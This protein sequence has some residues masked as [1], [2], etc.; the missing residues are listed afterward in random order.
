M[1]NNTNI[2]ARLLALYPFND[3]DTLGKDMSGNNNDAIPL[4]TTPPVI[5][6]VCGR[7]AALLT[8]G[9]AGT[10]YF[11]LPESIIEG[12]RDNDGLTI[13][14][15]MYLTRRGGVWERIIDLGSKAG[16][17][18]FFIT[19]NLR[20]V[21]AEGEDLAADPGKP[22]PPNEWVH[23]AMTVSG[24]KGGTLSNAGPAMYINGNLVS[25]G[26]ISQTTS[27]KY[28]K[29]RKFFAA[30]EDVANFPKRYIGRSLYDVDANFAGAFSDFRIY[31]TPLSQD[32]I[33]ELM[34]ASISDEE[35]LT[36]ATDKYLKMP[37]PIVTQDI[38]LPTSLMGGK[39][40]VSW[41]SDNS[42]ALSN[43]GVV[44]NISNAQ[45][46]NLTATLKRGDVSL[47][48]SINLSVIPTSIPPYTLI[49]NGNEKTVDISETLWGLFYE[50]I[51]NAADGGIYAELIQNRSFENFRFKNY[52]HSSGENGITE[53]R[54]HNP[55][56]AW[57]GDTDKMHPACE[58]GLND[59]FGLDDKDINSYYVSVDDGAVIYNKGFCDSNGYC[60]MSII[61]NEKYDFTV[62]A[63][64]TGSIELTLVDKDDRAVSN[65]VTLAV[66]TD[67][68]KK[69]GVDEKLVF[70]ATATELS[71][72]KMVFKG[73][74][75]IDMVS[76]F[77][78]NVWGAN[79]ESSSKTAHANFLGNK[80]YRLR[81]DLVKALVNLHPTFLRFP[82]GCISEGS[83]IWDNVYDW[84]DSV[85][86]V[87]FR[88]ENFN[89]W[90]YAMTM[91]LGY[92]EYFQLA[93]DLGATPLPVMACG[94]LC[95]A[96]SDYA[97]PAGGELQKKYIKNFTDLID[98]AISTDFDNN[99][100]AALRKKMGHEA[101]FD[102]HY[103]GV[104]NENW[105][106]EFMASFES[107]TKPLHHM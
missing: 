38:E 62:W 71:Q 36:F 12:I 61:A 63:K 67:N 41:Y 60:S 5:S 13:S 75:S 27:G 39:V 82:G 35:I 14:T 17:S 66:N 15:W 57:F 31:G 93:E 48:K 42:D 96:R 92:M 80:N 100:W 65:T 21:C 86:D 37:E 64:G 34:C 4:G 18:N 53:G 45:A 101:P 81:K 52:D 28:G 50:D 68:W 89:V 73:T 8:G 7:K 3:E 104:G 94:V 97:N 1:S 10:S 98:F 29:L 106:P 88:K 76:L 16:K 20:G 78:E 51:N 46:A 103:L 102:L 23:I 85:D 47:T 54:I 72:L 11:E 59:F 43:D 44:G 19:K 70:T 22:L 95:Q 9:P 40:E 24:S 69:Y 99:I 79:E 105:G 58:G 83:Y 87:E 55:L 90:G 30:F 26:R 77:P 91:G 84:K 32:D 2:D 107:S 56:F 25:D 49:V 74:L 33:I 6:E